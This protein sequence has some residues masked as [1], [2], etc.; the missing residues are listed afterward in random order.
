MLITF[1]RPALYSNL[2]LRLPSYF[3]RF[4]GFVVCLI[5]P[6]NEEPHT[7]TLR[8]AAIYNVRLPEGI[9][10]IRTCSESG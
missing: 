6:F 1:I 5:E 10:K 2:I 8:Q 3:Y 9:T 4:I 7:F